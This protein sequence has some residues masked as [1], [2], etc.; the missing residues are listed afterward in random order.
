MDCASTGVDDHMYLFVTDAILADEVRQYIVS[1]T[2]LN[3][4]A[5]KVIT[6]DEIPK[7]DAGKTLYKELEIYYR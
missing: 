4:A 6:I 3:R 5:F 1:K 7:N 2:G